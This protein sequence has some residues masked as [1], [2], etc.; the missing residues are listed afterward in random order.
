MRLDADIFGMVST[1]RAGLPDTDQL[2]DAEG[3]DGR[4]ESPE[5]ID[6]IANTVRTKYLLEHNCYVHSAQAGSEGIMRPWRGKK[7]A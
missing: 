2:G 6:V 3:D 5:P 1:C 7:G 4:A